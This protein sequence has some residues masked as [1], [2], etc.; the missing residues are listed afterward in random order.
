MFIEYVPFAKTLPGDVQ[1]GGSTN[2][3]YGLQHHTATSTVEK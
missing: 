1:T 2:S 3:S